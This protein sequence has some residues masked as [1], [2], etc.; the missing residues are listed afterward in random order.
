MEAQYGT[1]AAEAWFAGT[2]MAMNAEGTCD[3]HY[4]DGDKLGGEGE[5]GGAKG[6][7]RQ[8]AGGA[9]PRA[10][11]ID[12]RSDSDSDGSGV[13]SD[14]SDETYV[15]IQDA[16][17]GAKRR[18]LKYYEDRDKEVG[19]PWSRVRA[20]A[21]DAESGEDGELGGELEEGILGGQRTFEMEAIAALAW[22]GEGSVG[23]HAATA[24]ED[25][26]EDGDE[27]VFAFGGK[28]GGSS[29]DTKKKKRKRKKQMLANERSGDVP[30]GASDASAMRS[31][32]PGR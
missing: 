29:A 20:S 19:K 3:V 23:V 15:A 21:V 17:T 31:P 13:L 10:K 32:N 5:G 1:D 27:V 28:G 22:C 4:E 9:A 2:A 7:A 8:S 25:G 16:S 14:S 12:D 30:V 6:T 18:L 24:I 26:E 11:D